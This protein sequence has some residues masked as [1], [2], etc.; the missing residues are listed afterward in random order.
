MMSTLLLNLGQSKR[1]LNRPFLLPETRWRAGREVFGS[2]RAGAL[3]PS[4][5]FPSGLS[6]AAFSGGRQRQRVF[7]SMSAA[8][9]NE[10]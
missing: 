2:P 3:I 10:H 6:A 9:R 4:K 5:T 1:C 8:L 7:G